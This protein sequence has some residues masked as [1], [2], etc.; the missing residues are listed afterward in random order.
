MS[1]RLLSKITVILPFL[2]IGVCG[3]VCYSN[4]FNTFFLSDD[5]VLI[6]LYSK[7]GAWGLWV[8][9][10]HGN[11]LFF[12]PVLSIISYFDYQIWGL[13]PWGYHITNFLFHGLNAIWIGWIAAL[14]L[15]RQ[16]SLSIAQKF[17]PYLAAAIFLLL[18]SHTEPVS[19]IS[20][21]TDVIST[22]FALS[23]LGLYLIYKHNN[24][25]YIK[26]GSLFLFL[27]GL[28]SK[29]SIVSFP[30]IIFCYEIYEYIFQ[31]KY[32][33]TLKYHFLNIC[34]YFI[35]LMIYFGLRL[36]KI[37][38]IVGGYGEK[39]HLNFGV[40]QVLQNIVI[41]PTRALLPPHPEADF[42]YWLL[43]FIS[44]IVIFIISL[45]MSRLLHSQTSQL[46]QLLIFLV[47]SFFIAVLPAINVTVSTI[48]TQ[49]ERYLY[50]ASGFAAISLAI[51]IS[52]VLIQ[53]QITLIVS[54]ILLL[55]FGLS[56]YSL[57]QNWK[58]A[59][60]I[61]QNILESIQEI[62]PSTPALITSLPDNYQGAYIYRTGLIQALYLFD[63]N[64][65]F[66]IQ[67]IRQET[68]KNFE[69]V[70]FET[71]Q[72]KVMMNHEVLDTADTVMIQNFNPNIYQCQLSNPQ[73]S[74]L[75]WRKYPFQ[76]ETYDITSLEQNQYQFNIKDDNEVGSILQYSS[77]QL[78]LF[79][80]N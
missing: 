37:N 1:S 52:I 43:V 36:W 4:I 33:N 55:Y 11:S 71:T 34:Q 7:L 58:I 46:P 51:I 29:E 57:N 18:P 50:F 47:I 41:Y 22:F 3:I 28:L 10:Q 20:A 53:S 48:D 42:N 17:I 79:K 39:V 2:L 56:T 61:S 30:G 66:N 31:K 70:Q 62:Q 19:W 44:F 60:D 75:A 67:F 26:Y 76:T 12:R 80:N 49:G 24:N 63:E 9:Q 78:E 64:N 73:A 21:R 14:L 38:T 15:S 16:Y 54:S 8:N 32:R 6:A 65:Q 5:F 45:V 35:V 68:D 72:I 40:Q 74:F 13:K 77:Q 69:K 27:L 59:A 25:L 23:A